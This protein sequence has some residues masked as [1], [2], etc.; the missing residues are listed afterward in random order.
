V[1]LQD[2][3]DAIDVTVL[4]PTGDDE[5]FGGLLIVQAAERPQ[6]DVTLADL[7]SLAQLEEG[8]L[9]PRQIVESRPDQVHGASLPCSSRAQ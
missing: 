2:V 4:E 7:D 8:G 3:D 9:R 1:A 5:A 6:T